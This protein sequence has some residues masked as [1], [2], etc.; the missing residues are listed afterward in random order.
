MPTAV[1]AAQAV[2]AFG[3]IPFE[4]AAHS[5]LALTNNRRD[6]RGAQMLIRSANSTIRVRV[7]KRV[8]RVVR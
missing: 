4:P 5:L 2:H 8:L 1:L 7:R 3:L 6:G